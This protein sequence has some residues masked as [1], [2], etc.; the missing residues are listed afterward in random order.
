MKLIRFEADGKTRYG[1]LRGQAIDLIGGDIFGS[2]S[3]TGESIDLARARILPPVVPPNIIAIGLNYRSHAGESGAEIPVRPVI[4]LKATTSVI[5]DGETIVLPAPAPDEVDFE[6]ELCVVIGRTA[7]DVSEEDALGYAL[8]YTCGNDVS[9]RDCQR[10]L[11]AQW[12][13]GKSFDTFCPVGPHI[14]TGIGDPQNLNVISRVNGK[15]MQNSNTRDMIFPV[16]RLISYCSHNM[17][18]LPGTLIMTGT[19]D[20]VGFARNPPV[21]L[22]DGDAVEIEVEGVGTLRN[23]VSATRK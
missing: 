10:R 19:P 12:A 2:H 8:G 11:D 3:V 23:I 18:L 6:A 21:F 22:R 9:A 4:F 1:S 5:A 7:K 17:T 13:R 20:G 14:E 15:V 16:R